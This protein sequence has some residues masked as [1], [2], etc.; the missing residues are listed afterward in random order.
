MATLGEGR[1]AELTQIKTYIEAKELFNLRTREF[2]K[3]PW[4]RKRRQQLLSSRRRSE[5][6]MIDQFRKKFGL[7]SDVAI[8]FGD[9]RHADLGIK[10]WAPTVKERSLS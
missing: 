7:P 3:Q 5:D 8:G 1:S 4:F 6:Q 2:Y 9:W 10:S